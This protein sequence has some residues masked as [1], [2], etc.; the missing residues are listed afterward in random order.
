MS[1]SCP[2]LTLA[3]MLEAAAQWGYKGLEPRIDAGHAHGIETSLTPAARQA[4]RQQ[5][6][7]SPVTLC[8]LA[9]SAR[10]ADPDTCGDYLD[11][12]RR[13]LDL[14][15][16]LD[17]PVLRIFGGHFPDTVDRAAAIDSLAEAL[18]TLTDQAEDCDTTLCLETH[19]AWCNPHHVVQVLEQVNHPRVAANWDVLHPVRTTEMTLAESLA[20]LSP[21]IRHVHMHDATLAPGRIHYVP[22]GTGAIDHRQVIRGLQ[23]IAYTGYMSGEWIGYT[24]WQEHLPD[25]MARLQQVE[26]NLD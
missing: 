9:S 10:F 6:A 1:F 4:V 25:E 5:V 7:A 22:I 24:P 3:E 16:D 11:A 21:W 23:A 13:E 2:D 14:A 20:I 15:A 18:A 17:I 19:D 8:C 26:A 12:T